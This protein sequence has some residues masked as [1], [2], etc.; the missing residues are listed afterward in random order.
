V[1]KRNFFV[2]WF[3]DNGRDFPWRR[4]KT[5]PFQFLVT[6]ILL[7]QTKAAD[8]AK[9]WLDFFSEFPDALALA[10]ADVGKLEQK[11]KFLGFGTRRANALKMIGEWLV[12]N[13]AGDV[14]HNRERLLAIPFV[15]L[16]AAHAVLCFAFD[17]KI[18]IVD[19][20]VIR[21]FNRYYGMQLNKDARRA[22]PSWEIARNL[23]PG[24]RAKAKPHNY[25]LLDF[26]AQICKP[27]KPLCEI[28]P[29]VKQCC[30]GQS[31]ITFKNTVPDLGG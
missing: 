18:E 28:C 10:Q 21:L 2:K 31:K 12:E 7:Q 29:L 3:A 30:Y 27:V 1:I 17:R 25:G 13:H 6:E 15:G 19:A 5:T 8:V 23:L 16:Y 20:N 14:P 4:D 26:T 22:P 9:I 24:E 11:I